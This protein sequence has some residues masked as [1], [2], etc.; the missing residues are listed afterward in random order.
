MIGVYTILH[1][2]SGKFYVGSSNN[3]SNRI[4]THKR[5]LKRNSHHCNHLQRAWNLYGENEFEFKEFIET[6]NLQKAR[7]VEQVYIDLFIKDKL[8]NT[9]N[10]AIGAASGEFN[11]AK[12]SNWHMKFVMKNVSDEERKRRYGKMLGV[13]NTDE[14]KKLKSLAS[15]ARWENTIDTEKRKLAMRGKREVVSCPHCDISGGGGNM[16]R[17]H[18]DKCK[19]HTNE[20]V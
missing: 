5:E 19:T 10:K 20:S 2:T 13:K 15:K 7:E 1:K 14:T 12:K 3:I 6:I 9:K 18:F 11:P 8:Y 17:Y 4:V 16:K